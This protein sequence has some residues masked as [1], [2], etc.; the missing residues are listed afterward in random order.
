MAGSSA[1]AG[2]G[3]ILLARRRGYEPDAELCHDGT[4][5]RC[6][7][8]LGGRSP[9]ELRDGTRPSLAPRVDPLGG[10]LPFLLPDRWRHV[11]RL[12]L[13]ACR[14]WRALPLDCRGDHRAS[15]LTMLTLHGAAS[16]LCSVKAGTSLRFSRCPDLADAVAGF[17]RLKL[18]LPRRPPSATPASGGTIRPMCLAAISVPAPVELFALQ[19]EPYR[20]A[21]EVVNPSR[22]AGSTRPRSR[23]TPSS[24]RRRSQRSTRPYHRSGRRSSSRPGSCGCFRS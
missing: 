6:L 12:G 15:A 21:G 17:G 3:T 13:A 8:H 19:D 2:G 7:P 1:L 18:P 5:T 24:C 22:R 11:R 10:F 16:V 4:R 20:Q 9:I 23:P 14:T